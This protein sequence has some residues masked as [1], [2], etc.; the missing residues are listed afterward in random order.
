MKHV[1][2][3]C[4]VILYDI[5]HALSRARSRAR[6]PSRRWDSPSSTQIALVFDFDGSSLI[7]G[8]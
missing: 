5:W 1:S 7:D 2:Y 3:E 6:S 4:T 8:V